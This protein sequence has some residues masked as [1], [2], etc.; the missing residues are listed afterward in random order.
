MRGINQSGLSPAAVESARRLQALTRVEAVGLLERHPDCHW[1]RRAM[2][3]DS[4]ALVVLLGV[5]WVSVGKRTWPALVWRVTL[6]GK[7]RAVSLWESGATWRTDTRLGD[8]VSWG[9]WAGRADAEAGVVNGD[10]PARGGVTSA[11]A[12]SG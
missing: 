9:S 10:E 1:L 3:P 8:S 12:S 11:A 5:F 4:T 6:A 7:T 2:A